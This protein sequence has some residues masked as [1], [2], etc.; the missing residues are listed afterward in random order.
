MRSSPGCVGSVLKRHL[1]W[2]NNEDCADFRFILS[3]ERYF[4]LPAA[5]FVECRK[6]ETILIGFA[7]LRAINWALAI[8]GD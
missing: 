6:N 8:T 5:I 3:N 4:V 2:H 1:Q 7:K